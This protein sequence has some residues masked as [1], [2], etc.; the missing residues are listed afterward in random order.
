MAHSAGTL[1]QPAG[2]PTFTG[3][4]F[5]TPVLTANTAY[6]IVYT[7]N[8]CAGSA[9]F[10]VN[11]LVDDVPAAPVAA[12]N[13]VT[14]NIGQTA[15]LT[16]TEAGNAAIKWYSAATGGTALYTGNTFTTPVLTANT[17]YY[18]EAASGSCVSTART[19]V[20]VTVTP[21]VIPNVMVT[22]P[23][24]A[25]DPG[26][27]ATF[28]ASSTTPGAVFNWYTTPTGGTSIFTGPVFTTPAEVAGTT[29][30]AE[31]SVPATGAVSAT[32]GNRN[33]YY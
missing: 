4:N 28:S 15:M 13:N 20:T 24:Q 6:Y 22:P 16:A 33:G 19:P 23:I 5:T 30:Y 3:A 17:T 2:T 14:I 12:A 27:T 32:R 25:V 26:Q 10:P 29:Y 8:G 18:A 21:V 31:A 7:R 1:R 11:I 9:R